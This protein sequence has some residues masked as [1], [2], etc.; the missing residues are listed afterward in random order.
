MSW[1]TDLTRPK[2]K[3]VSTDTFKDVP[4]NLWSKCPKCEGMLYHRDLENNFYVCNHCGYCLRLS[5]KLRFAH[6]FDD[7]AYEEIELP[8]S[9]K[10]DPLGFKDVKRYSERLREYRKKTGSKNDAFTLALGKIGAHPAVVGV[11]DF[12]FG[13]GSMGQAVGEGIVAAA[14]LAVM[15]NAALILIPSSGGARMQEGMISLMQMPRTVYAVNHVKDNGLPYIVIMANPVMGGVSAS[16]AML[17]DIIL[18]EPLAEIGF[19]GRIVIERFIRETLPENFL[20]AENLMENGMVDMVV[21][22]E[23]LPDT[24]RTIL[25]HLF[26]P[27][28]KGLS[29]AEKKDALSPFV[30]ESRKSKNPAKS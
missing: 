18:S 13:G 14:T 10:T 24:L 3:E 9:A 19:A 16:F 4:D 21:K 15:E 22:R 25:A 26:A 6:L 8:A 23:D 30:K 1:L 7:G 11:L 2:I 29:R 5:S 20:A 17:G 27:V 28:V 12:D